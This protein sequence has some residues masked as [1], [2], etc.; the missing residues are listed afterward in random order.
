M[1]R[2]RLLKRLKGLTFERRPVDDQP[3]IDHMVTAH[4]YSRLFSTITHA[5]AWHPHFQNPLE[6]SCYYYASLGAHL[7]DTLKLSDRK[8]KTVGGQSIYVMQHGGRIVD[9]YAYAPDDYVNG[10]DR[11]EAKHVLLQ[12]GSDKTGQMIDL[13][14]LA[15]QSWAAR[16]GYNNP[17]VPVMFYREHSK[18][19]AFT[20]LYSSEAR[21]RCYFDPKPKHHREFWQNEWQ[22]LGFES[23]IDDVLE[24][25]EQGIVCKEFDRYD[26][27]IN[28]N[29]PESY[30]WPE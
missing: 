6:Q 27:Y 21:L 1:A 22:W 13:Q 8:V 9:R 16:N 3:I 11:H 5:M 19:Y 29:D 25:W 10:P 7:I 2:R 20:D 18:S 15:M 4:G 26:K 28:H 14:A 23:L 17:L 30:I 12:L 24:I